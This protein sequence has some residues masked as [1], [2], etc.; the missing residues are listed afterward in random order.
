M[1]FGQ[2]LTV[3]FPGNFAIPRSTLRT[4]SY[5]SVVSGS[6]GPAK[7]GVTALVTCGT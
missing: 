3:V 6:W 5:S 2:A 7:L 1:H 4:C